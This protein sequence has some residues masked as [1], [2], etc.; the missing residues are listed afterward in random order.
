MIYKTLFSFISLFFF[1]SQIIYAQPADAGSDQE[2]CSNHTFLEAVEPDPGFTGTWSVISGFCN[3]TDIHHA[4]S[5][6][7]GLMEGNTELKW[8]ITDGTDTYFDNVIIVNNSPT[9]ATTGDDE[10]ICEDTYLLSANAFDIDE[11]GLWTV[12]FGSGT[13]SNATIGFTDVNGIGQG[14]NTFRWTISKGICD[15]Y[16]DISIT[17]NEV[18]ANAGIDNTT[19]YDF[20][21]LSAENP[22]VGTGTWSIVSSSGSPVFADIHDCTTTVS[23]LGINSNSLQWTVTNF[24]C[25]TYDNIIITSHKPTQAFAGIDKT[26]CTNTT[27][28]SAGNPTHGTGTWSVVSGTGHF[29]NV[30][31]YNSVVNNIS[32]FANTY[33]WTV[34]YFS[35]ISEDEVIVYYDYFTAY[36]GVDDITCL[37]S[38]N[39]NADDPTPGTGEWRVTGGSGTFANPAQYNTTVSN[40][41]V[42]ENTYEWKIT[43]GACIQTDY[44]TITRNSASIANAGQDRVTCNGNVTMAAINPVVG[45]GSWSVIS[46]SGHFAD[47]NL[48]NTAVS[49]VG[50]N[51]NTYRWTVTYASCSNYDDASVSNNYVT[52]NAGIDQIICGSTSSLNGNEPQTG[53]TGIWQLLAGTSTISNVNL[54]NTNVS[55]LSSGLNKYR[56]SISKG[57]CNAYDDIEIIN[58]L[59]SA[60]ASVSGP[61]DICN[62]HAEILGNSPP[63]GGIGNWS[64]TS[65]SGIF[66][67]SN[68]QST[69]VRDLAVGENIIRWSINKAGCINY[70]EIEINRNAVNADAGADQNICNNSTT[71]T[72]NIVLP[73]ESGL[74]SRVSGTGTFTNPTTN[75]TV[76][77][78]ILPG[79]STYRWTITKNACSDFDDI[80]VTN[81]TFYVSAGTDQQICTSYTTLTASD[82]TPGYGYWQVISGTGNFD[83]ASHHTTTVTD[84]PNYSVSTF[85]WNAFKNSCTAFDDVIIQNNSVTAFAGEDAVVCNDFFTLQGNNPAPGSGVWTIQ[86][87]GGI[88]DEINNP[89]SQ[90]T[91]LSQ[92]MNIIRWTISHLTCISYDEVMITNYSLSATAGPD[93]AICENQTQL[94]G[95]APPIGGTG[96]WE[97]VTG[98]GNFDNASLYNTHVSNLNSG[99]NTFKW[100]IFNNGCSSDGDEVIINNKSFTAYAGENQILEQF[101]TE[102]YMQ[103]DL[104]QGGTGEW[105]LLSGG[106]TISNI[107][108]PNAFISDLSNGINTFRWFV[109]YNACS[110][111]DFVDITAID[112][113]AYAGLDKT[114]CTDELKLNARDDG[115][116]P[117]IWTVI[118]GQG[119]FDDKNQNDTWVRNVGIGENIYRWSVTINGATDYDDIS[120]VRLISEAGEEQILCENHTFLSANIPQFGSTGSWS[121]VAGSGTFASSTLYNTEVSNLSGNLNMFQW[122]ISAQGYCNV[123]DYV[124]INYNY[125]FADA[126]ND[127]LLCVDFMTMNADQPQTGVQGLWTLVSGF[128]EILTPTLYNTQVLNVNPGNNILKWTVSSEYC[129]HEDTVNIYNDEAVAFAGENQTINQDFTHLEAELPQN[130]TG[131]WTLEFGFGNLEDIYNPSTFVSEL[132][133]GTNIFKWTVSNENCSDY[134]VVHINYNPTDIVDLIENIRIYPNP[135]HNFLTVENYQNLEITVEIFDLIGRKSNSEIIHGNTIQNINFTEKS[136]GIYFIHIST[137]NK[138]EYIQKILKE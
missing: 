4:N 131:I 49:N 128:G 66:D 69:T 105:I 75:T 124:F 129:Q 99:F 1:L 97:I 77:N 64:I 32:H 55:S 86:V 21:T 123:S 37:N 24:N 56:W 16:D 2:V 12:E 115:G 65:G 71:I 57:T 81:N 68:D 74:W 103:A 50:L 53:E 62:D 106:A 88:I 110:S 52:A 93:K 58:N 104:P 122:T 18:S 23:N 136:D 76:V 60:S 7:T 72:G 107:N 96:L 83:N 113:D 59:Y 116:S 63:T 45:T 5:E 119:V 43:H 28:L 127:E 10:E 30:N 15:T 48:N 79:V 84:L 100:T 6:I 134:D 126:G 85:R 40:M 20:Y 70:D 114:I 90:I 38:Y 125:V 9:S 117:Q 27:S 46:G 13:F 31:A 39:L 22:I 135:V 94:A 108:D 92:N 95:Q 112:F 35:C 34:S 130:V 17:N 36:A 87:G 137:Q 98:Y 29:I 121:V 120:V 33:K 101:V 109:E 8:S 61:S 138:H 111:F 41:I 118:Q 133:E 42:G 82:P 51:S 102:T 3:I 11:A 26:I 91:E 14:L 19:C 67:D 80:L 54:Y 132:A 44:I 25:S 78:G 73:G 89:E 47:S